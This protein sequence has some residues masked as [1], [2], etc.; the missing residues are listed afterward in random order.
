MKTLTMILAL[1]LVAAT[2]VAATIL[3]L[4]GPLSQLAPEWKLGEQGKYGDA[5]FQW[6]WV[7]FTNAQGDVL[8]L[9]SH[10]LQAGEQR[11][12]IYMSDTAHESFCD[13]S[14]MWTRKSDKVV[15]AIAESIRN[16]IV[17][18]DVPSSPTK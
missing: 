16:A 12:L 10:C 15:G 1:S 3:P 13:G 8:S 2:T 9:A 18:L 17:K 6:H 11:D 7:L 4:I 5:S 14:P